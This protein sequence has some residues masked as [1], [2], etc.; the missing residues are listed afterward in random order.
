MKKE[1]FVDKLKNETFK[2]TVASYF[3]ELG[4]NVRTD[5][6]N[7]SVKM[8]ADLVPSEDEDV[9]VLYNEIF[10]N[11]TTTTTT[12]KT[13]RAKTIRVK[14]VGLMVFDV[15]KEE[16]TKTDPNKMRFIRGALSIVDHPALDTNVLRLSPTQL[17]H[18][19]N[20]VFSRR[21]ERVDIEKDNE[22]QWYELQDLINSGANIECSIAYSQVRKGDKYKIGEEEFEHENDF[23]RT[24]V[25]MVFVPFRAKLEYQQYR[26]EREINLLR[27]Q[28]LAHS[29]EE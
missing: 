11:E 20:T 22:E 13:P 12:V 6:N 25:V 14:V 7:I 16:P 21:D 3:E 15:T 27:K 26:D 2:A 19:F 4:Q 10:A 24:S 17:N 28:K 1:T 23:V 5:K 9:Q 29:L 18:L 8:I